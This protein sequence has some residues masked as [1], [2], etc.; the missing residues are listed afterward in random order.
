MVSLHRILLVT[1][2]RNLVYTST[3]QAPARFDQA[4]V[5]TGNPATFLNLRR[6]FIST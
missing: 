2:K 6:I 3:L 5:R 1:T 4:R